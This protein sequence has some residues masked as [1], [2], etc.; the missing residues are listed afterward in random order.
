MNFRTVSSNRRTKQR[1]SPWR[2]SPQAPKSRLHRSIVGPKMLRYRSP[3]GVTVAPKTRRY[4]F[5]FGTSDRQECKGGGWRGG[6]AG[7]VEASNTALAA[8]TRQK[9][10]RRGENVHAR[11]GVGPRG[12][13]LPCGTTGNRTLTF[14]DESTYQ[15]GQLDHCHRQKPRS[16]QQHSVKFLTVLCIYWSISEPRWSALTVDLRARTA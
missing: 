16:R 9:E 8:V 1:T 15:K 6:Y 3:L 4:R 7:S 14:V 12:G 2:R 11:Y 10:T 13:S 5:Q